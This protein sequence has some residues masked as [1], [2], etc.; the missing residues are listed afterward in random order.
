MSSAFHW[1]NEPLWIRSGTKATQQIEKSERSNFAFPKYGSEVFRSL[2]Y[3]YRNYVHQAWM[4]STF[5]SKCHTTAPHRLGRVPQQP[6]KLK[7][8]EKNRALRPQGLDSE[9]FQVYP[10]GTKNMFM[11]PARA[12]LFVWGVPRRWIVLDWAWSHSSPIMWKHKIRKYSSKISIRNPSNLTQ[13]E[14]NR[15]F[16]RLKKQ[17]Y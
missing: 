8:S 10:R 15:C 1:N 7:N 12:L 3:L 14:R 5:R 2:P 11:R 16:C 6:K 9:S 4:R 13:D 17:Y